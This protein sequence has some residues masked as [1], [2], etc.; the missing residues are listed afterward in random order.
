MYWTWRGLVVSIHAPLAGR[1]VYIIFGEFDHLRFNPRAPR[2]ARRRHCLDR[3]PVGPS[4]NPRAPRGARLVSGAARSAGGRFQSTRPSRGATG[5]VVVRARLALVSI[6]APL[7]G[8]DPLSALTLHAIRKFQST[9]PS[10]GATRR[11]LNDPAASLVSIH[12]PLAGRD[13]CFRP[14]AAAR[15]W[16]QST[17]P[18]RGATSSFHSSI[19]PLPRFNPRAPRGARLDAVSIYDATDGVSIHAPLAGRDSAAR[20]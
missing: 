11:D 10:R 15:P 12:A 16:F 9:R 18:S 2:G 20:I 8:R 6:H 19:P 13:T 5:A 7:A 17:R 4:F 1:D 14:R 3:Y